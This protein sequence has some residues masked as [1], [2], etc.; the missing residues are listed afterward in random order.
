M[1]ELYATGRIVDVILALV[2]LEVLVLV[3]IHRRT[4]RGIAPR[5]LLPVVLAGVFLLL[6]VRC[7]LVAAEWPWIGACLLA[8]MLAHGVDLVCRARG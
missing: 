7:A 1:A 5:A 8:A 3:A 2:A 4:G 6:A